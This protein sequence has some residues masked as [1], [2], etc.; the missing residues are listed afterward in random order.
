MSLRIV[1]PMPPA[2][3]LGMA[4]ASYAQDPSPT[5]MRPAQMPAESKCDKLL[6][7]A[8]IEMPSAVGMRVADAQSDIR[9]ARNSAIRGSTRRALRSSAVSWTPCTK[10]AEG[11]KPN[12]AG[13]NDALRAKLSPVRARHSGISRDASEVQPIAQG[14]RILRVADFPK[15]AHSALDAQ[16]RDL[17]E[18]G[19]SL[20]ISGRWR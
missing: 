8:E 17:P 19:R 20:T 7:Q 6:R 11:V 15:L 4:G 16:Q 2:L 1:L 18:P 13:R 10:A 9:E 12:Q 3:T 5:Q 14:P